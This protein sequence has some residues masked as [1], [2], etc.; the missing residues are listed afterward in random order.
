MK[1]YRFPKGI[2]VV[3]CAFVKN[4]KGEILLVKSP[5][6]KGKWCMPGGHIEPGET[7]K[8]SFIR[9][10]KEELGIHVTWQ[11]IFTFGEIIN[12][13][14]FHRPAHFIYFV[15]LLTCPGNLVKIDN[16]EIS[17]C[18]WVKPKIALSMPLVEVYRKAIKKYLL[19][20]E[21]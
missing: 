20:Q 2:E 15:A 13:P 4:R 12:P 10:A 11:G 9:E 3:N 18:K 14:E 1:N 8:H 21:Y 6:W 7:L 16:N 17:E 5:K 19:N